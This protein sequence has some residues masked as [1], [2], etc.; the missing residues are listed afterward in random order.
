MLTISFLVLSKLEEFN[1]IV[2][3]LVVPFVFVM[4]FIRVGFRPFKNRGLMAYVVL[5][6]WAS[7]SIFYT[8]NLSTTF[9][10]LQVMIGNVLLWYIVDSYINSNEKMV[11][12]MIPLGFAFVIHL[13]FGLTD[14]IDPNEAGFD[15]AQ[16]LLTKANG[17]AFLLWCGVVIIS[18]F[19]IKP[20]QKKIL[21]LLFFALII[22]FSYGIFQTGSRK[23]LF[24]LFLFLGAILFH[25]S[26]SKGY[27]TFFATLV[28]LYFMYDYIYDYLI[29]NT[30]VGSR[31]SDESLDRG[32]TGRR[33]LINEGFSF[34]LNFPILGIGLG[35]FTSLSSSGM[36]A[37]ND[38]IEIL[39]SMGL[40]ALLI[41][42]FIFYDYFKKNRSLLKSKSR[43]F[44]F[45][46]VAQSF[47]LGYL[48]LGMGRPSF[49]DPIAMFIFAFFQSAVLKYYQLEKTNQKTQKHAYLPPYQH[50]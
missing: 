30:V 11:S 41:Y 10:Y 1:Q 8:E 19:V 4:C 5:I 40:P 18:Y 22:M 48:F 21:T 36:I 3:K 28:L 37:H 50:A 25:R 43:L 26:G 27:F 47:L 38:Y 39:A 42:L 34:F 13:Y 7:M 12:L 33:F 49:L 6:G 2:L 9:D 24:S 20:N 29:E 23:A 14:P 46:V 45:A 17:L 31:L 16:G 15:R 35:S 44:E 32:A